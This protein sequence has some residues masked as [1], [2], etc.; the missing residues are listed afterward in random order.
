MTTLEKRNI[1]SCNTLKTNL[2][3][4]PLKLLK[5]YKTMLYTLFWGL[6]LFCNR[7][8]EHTSELQSQSNLVCRLLLV[9]KE[10]ASGDPDPDRDRDVAGARLQHCGARH[11]L[12]VRRVGAGQERE[13]RPVHGAQPR[14]FGVVS[15]PL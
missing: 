13:R 6:C 5:K 14:T 8:E 3:S 1:K 10:Q 12:V 2:L 7:S 15:A 11:D 9:K 4:P